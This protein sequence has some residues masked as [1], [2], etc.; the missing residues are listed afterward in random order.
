MSYR[1]LISRRYDVLAEAEFGDY[2]G[3]IL[4]LIHDAGREDRERCLGVI[5]T[6]YGSC[7][8]CDAYDAAADDGTLDELADQL[9]RSAVWGTEHELKLY[10][11]GPDAGLR[12]YFHEEDF[13]EAAHTAFADQV[14]ALEG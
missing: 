13:T 9:H 7:S 12:W 1:D 4:F 2:Q 3:D 14:K 8:G 6:G 5:I 11:L 10:L